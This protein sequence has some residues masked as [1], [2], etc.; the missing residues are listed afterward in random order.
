M[1]GIHE[2]SRLGI[3]IAGM[4]VLVARR[5]VEITTVIVLSALVTSFSIFEEK[6]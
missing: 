2:P 1:K 5:G 4:I 3:V 6:L